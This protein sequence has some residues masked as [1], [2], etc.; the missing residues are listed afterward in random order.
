[1]H[2][3]INIFIVSQE[4]SGEGTEVP[5]ESDMPGFSAEWTFYLQYGQA[6]G[7]EVAVDPSNTVNEEEVQAMIDAHNTVEDPHAG[8]LVKK[9]DLMAH[10][11]NQKNPHGVTKDQVGLGNVDNTADSQK[12]VAFASEA[13]AANKV[14]YSV[15]IRFNGGRTEGTDMWTYDGATSRSINITPEKIGAAKADHT[16]T[17]ADVGAIPADGGTVAGPLTLGGMLIRTEGVHYGDTL[18]APGNK[19]RL[20]FKRVTS[21]VFQNS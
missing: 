14:K 18:P 19:G 10:V 3:I 5:A 11:V 6:D 2:F 9:T 7:V 8:V 4:S 1:M 15:I 16:H 13:G 20:F 17:A 12:Y 21:H